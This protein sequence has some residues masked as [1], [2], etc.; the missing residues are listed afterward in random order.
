MTYSLY[1]IDRQKKPVAYKTETKN[2]THI[3][4]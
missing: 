4:D 2:R 1:D 3:K